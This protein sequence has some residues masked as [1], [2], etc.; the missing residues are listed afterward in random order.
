MTDSVPRAKKVKL[1][2]T[3]AAGARHNPSVNPDCRRRIWLAAAILIAVGVVVY[4]SS[5]KGGFFDDDIGAIRDNPHIRKLWPLSEAMSIPL[6]SQY[7]SET[8]FGRPI[9]SLSFAL[10]YALLG[11]QPWG[12]HLVNLIIHISAALLLFGIIRR[13]LHTEQFRQRYAQRALPLALAVALIW[14]VHPLQ[15]ESVTQIVQRAESMM[16]MFFLLT[17]YCAIRGFHSNRRG[18]WYLASVL[19]CTLGMGTKEVM[20]AAPLIVPLYDYV[21]VSK[22]LKTIL[23]QR[24]GFYIF[25]AATWTIV[26]ALVIISHLPLD[27][28]IIP[29]Q[30]YSHSVFELIIHVTT[31]TGLLVLTFWGLLRR[32]WLGFVGAW[33]F[34][35]LAPSSSFIPTQN[36]MA[37]QRM[38]LSLAAVVT[39]ILFNAD[40]FLGKFLSSSIRPS[41]LKILNVGFVAAIVAVFGFITYQQNKTY[42]SQ[43]TRWFAVL[44]SHP[45][46]TNV[47]KL[48]GNIFFEKNDLQQAIV[49]YENAIR[50]DPNTI[51]AH[52]NLGTVFVKQG[53]LERAGAEFEYE[54]RINPNYVE[55]HYNLGNVLLAQGKP[56][57]AIANYEMALELAPDNIM[58][59]NNLAWLLATH[60]KDNVRN[61]ARAVELAKHACNITDYKVPELLD[62]LATA[63][64]EENRFAEAVETA[65]KALALAKSQKRPPAKI[66]QIRLRLEQYKVQKPF[67]WQP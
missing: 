10:N 18:L 65:A 7:T 19:A 16:G 32:S 53:N 43:L 1:P 26:F 58:A 6:W 38:Y 20:V 48:I 23:R 37:G 17:L 22:S 60:P 24:G 59:M 51:K 55:A 56:D 15:T 30:K 36:F 62:T 46:N 67:R 14:L 11:P 28:L 21:F 12:Y 5:F 63:Y 57:Q 25:L 50:I 40:H 66:Q 3:L 42:E 9:L 34:C 39:I 45:D 8:V 64:A 27:F 35:I 29:V 2:D 52:F 61:G 49:Y 4:L 44:R 54:I 33:F 31:V 47:N 13:T 41:R